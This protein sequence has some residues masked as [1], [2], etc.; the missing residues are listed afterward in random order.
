MLIKKDKARYINTGNTFCVSANC[1][2]RHECDRNYIKLV[3]DGVLFPQQVSMADFYHP[4]A[5]Y[6]C[7][8]FIGGENE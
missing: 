5:T 1:P 6:D 8:Y 2:K 7:E 4:T 3:G